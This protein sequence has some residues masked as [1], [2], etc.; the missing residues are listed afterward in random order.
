ML[1]VYWSPTAAVADVR[2]P[3]KPHDLSSPKATLNTFLTTSDLLYSLIHEEYWHSPSRAIVDRIWD[4]DNELM[5]ML[6]LSGI[7]PAAHFNLA[8]DGIVYLYEVLSRIELPAEVDIPGGAAYAKTGDDQEAGHKPVSWTIPDTE[9]TLVRVAEGPRAGEFL[10]SSQ[11]V[12]RAKEFYEKTRTLPYLRDVPLKN[13]VE[14]RPYLSIGNWII[15]SATIEGFPDWLKLSA[16]KQAV[17]KWIALLILI[18]LTTTVIFVIHRLSR[19]GL[20]GHSVGAYLRRLVTPLVLILLTPLVLK[21]A[22]Q[23]LTLT[24]WVAGVI[25]LVSA[26][27]TYFA[28]AWVI[29]TGMMAFSEAIIASPRISDQSLNAH[30]LRLVART[31]AIVGILTIIIYVSSQLGI[32]LYGIVTGVGVGGLALALAVRPTLENVIGGLVLFLDKPVRVGDF[33][34]FGELEGE[35]EEIGLRSIRLRKRDDTLVSVPNAD[36]SQ[37]QLTNYKR[38]RRRLYETTLGLRYETSAEQ[39]RYVLAKLREM[40]LGHPKVSSD[41]LHVRFHD[42]G[43]YSLDVKVFAYIRTRDR[44]TYLAIREDINLRIIDIVLEAGTGFA[45]PSQ[46]VYLGRDSGLDA[47]RGRES[48]TQVQEWR[49]NGKLPFPEFDESLLEEK[50]GVLDYPPEGSPDFKPRIV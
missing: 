50:K 22:I 4:F 30:L 43:A 13:Y 45:F 21:M 34:R 36:F 49:S 48:E 19:R 29:W 25:G 10:F 17:W 33:C 31:A 9:I 15:P 6:D 20:S 11:T 28:L 12:R 38:R 8:R 40:L 46:T 44:L 1:L 24:G 18:A 27:V 35:V 16:Y 26:T 5:R 37:L 7:P 14:M 2:H 41:M 42:F 23:Q 3:L 47:E 32:P 39:L